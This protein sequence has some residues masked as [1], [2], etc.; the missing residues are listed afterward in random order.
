MRIL[1]RRKKGAT[2][3]EYGLL[4]ALIAI[5]VAVYATSVGNND[6]AIMCTVSKSLGGSGCGGGSSSYGYGLSP[7]PGMTPMPQGT[8]CQNQSVANVPAA[9]AQWAPVPPSSGDA[10]LRVCNAPGG[11]AYTATYISFGSDGSVNSQSFYTAGAVPNNATTDQ[12]MSYL[13]SS[14]FGPTPVGIYS[15]QQYITN[16]GYTPTGNTGSLSQEASQLGAL[17][18][19]SGSQNAAASYMFGVNDMSAGLPN[20]TTGGYIY[21]LYSQ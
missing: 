10:Y 20:Q 8:V 5:P 1:R 2:A 17:Y 12:V 16:A 9:D 3:I 11:A 13:F 21:D 19:T 15:N 18:I 7:L 6:S 14:M 4:A